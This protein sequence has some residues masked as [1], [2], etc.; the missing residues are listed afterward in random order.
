MKLF[1]TPIFSPIFSPMTRTLQTLSISAVILAG[2]TGFFGLLFPSIYDGFV[3]PLHIAESQGQD[4]TSLSLGITLLILGTYLA[5]KGSLKGLILL[6][7]AMGYLLYVNIIY[8]YGGVYNRLFFAYVAICGISLFSLISAMS[9]IGKRLHIID[10][11]SSRK[12]LAFFFLITGS[13]LSLMWGAMT[14]DAMSK[15]RVADANVIIVT[16]FMVIIPSYILC[17]IWLLKKKVWGDALSGILLIQ[18]I[19]LGVSIIAGQIIALWRE[20]E[21]SWGLAVFFGLFTVTALILGIAWWKTVEE[22]KG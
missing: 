6:A 18:A 22:T 11:R 2:V 5:K 21:P 15:G 14:I 10:F 7:G 1:D 19:T 16:D 13:M 4:F 8:A 3:S 20:I 12:G 9:E 17:A